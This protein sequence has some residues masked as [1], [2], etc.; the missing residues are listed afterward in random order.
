MYHFVYAAWNGS[1]WFKKFARDVSTAVSNGTTDPAILAKIAID[2]R[3]KEGLSDGSAPN[4]LI[5]QGGK[6]IEKMFGM[7]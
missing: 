5:A 4:Q 6:K 2:S 7:A 1:G 3:T